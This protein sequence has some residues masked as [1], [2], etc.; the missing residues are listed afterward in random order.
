VPIFLERFVLTVL[1]GG[2]ITL[3]ILN[4]LKWDWQQRTS[5]LVVIVAAAYFVAHTLTLKKPTSSQAPA[6]AIEAPRKTGDAATTGPN[7]PAVTGDSNQI[8][9]N[10]ASPDN[11]KPAKKKE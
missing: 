6:P 7:S 3:V 5:F 1:A 8:Q 2:V 11:Q 10:E 9:Y 4:P